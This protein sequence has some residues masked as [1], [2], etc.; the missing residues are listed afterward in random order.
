MFMSCILCTFVLFLFQLVGVVWLCA[1][2]CVF[3]KAFHMNNVKEYERHCDKQNLQPNTRHK[4]TNQN[5]RG[6]KARETFIYFFFYLWAHMNLQFSQDC[7]SQY[8]LTWCVCMLIYSF[9]WGGHT[10]YIQYFDWHALVHG[11]KIF[12]HMSKLPAYTL[13]CCVCL[14][15]SVSSFLSLHDWMC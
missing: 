2:L 6:G 11:C 1:Y 8:L 4:T 5:S 14:C 3:N 10:V 15:A 12:S 7:V 9:F 13:N